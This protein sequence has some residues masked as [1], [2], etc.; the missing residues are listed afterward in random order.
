MASHA[1][2]E[3]VVTI[4]VINVPSHTSQTEFNCWFLFAPGFEQGTL[5]PTR[6]PNQ[7]QLGWAR[8][9]TVETAQ[10]AIMHLNGRRLTDDQSPEGIVLSA[11]W[12][13]S[14]YRANA[15]ARQQ[16]HMNGL[17]PAPAPQRP[18]VAL[19][20]PP[21]QKIL[22]RA[23]PAAV[24][25]QNPNRARCS[26]L[27]LGGLPPGAL[28]HEMHAFLQSHCAGFDRLKFVTPSENKPGMG[29]AKFVTVE[30]AEAALQ[31]ISTGYAL[32]NIPT[33][34]LQADFAKHDLDQP[35]R[36]HGAMEMAQPAVIAPPLMAA[37]EY[38][39]HDYQQHYEAEYQHFEV[40]PQQHWPPPEAAPQ[41]HWPPPEMQLQQHHLATQ[42]H[43][44]AA[45][46]CDTMFIGN[47]PPTVTESEVTAVL[48]TLPGFIRV[49][50]VGQGQPR[51]VAFALFDSVEVCASAMAVLAGTALP[52]APGQFLTCEFS[53]N[54]LDKRQRCA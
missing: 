36:G 2:D 19:Q 9:S 22:P 13:K 12:A 25:G 27:F 53:K 26:T 49:K 8:F 17:P 47:L 28:E 44:E 33:F 7:S 21:L 5:V 11:D 6:G 20:P 32:P 50:L 40:T 51:P 18:N 34:M 39:H 14:N 45:V 29:F 41:Q 23:P 1:G 30:H 3:V 10:A 37:P 4:R 52:S 31:T 35:S 46:P 48:L 54:S 43:S 16:Q 24:A 15:I 42:Q 38:H